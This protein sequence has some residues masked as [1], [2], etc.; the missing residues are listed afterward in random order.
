[1]AVELVEFARSI[2]FGNSS[3]ASKMTNAFDAR[4]KSSDSIE[5]IEKIVDEAGGDVHSVS[6]SS[7]P[8]WDMIR[9][10]VATNPKYT[11]RCRNHPYFKD[12]LDQT[13]N[14]R[15]FE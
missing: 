3:D 14:G 8:S 2:D 12:L 13:Y 6:I 1:M 5:A 7:G 15:V 10:S 11:D 9:L 4:K